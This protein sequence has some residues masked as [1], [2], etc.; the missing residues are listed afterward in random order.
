MK[1]AC[2]RLYHHVV[3]LFSVSVPIIFGFCDQVLAEWTA[4]DPD[5]AKRAPRMTV[6]KSD[7]LSTVVRFNVFGFEQETVEI[8]GSAYTHITLPGYYESDRR[9]YP[10]VPRLHRDFVIPPS[11]R[12]SLKVLKTRKVTRDLGALKPSRGLLMRSENPAD[13]PYEFA[14]LYRQGGVYPRHP[15]DIGRPFTMRSVRGVNLSFAPFSYNGATG[16]T[17]ITTEMVVEIRTA[18]RSPEPARLQPLAYNDQAFL[19]I[20]TGHFANFKPFTDSL[21]LRYDFVP[22]SGRLLVITH[23]EFTDTVAALVDWKRQSGLDVDLITTEAETSYRDIK[24]LVKSAYETDHVGYVLLAGDAEFIPYHVGTSGNVNGNEADPM[25]ALVAGNDSYPDLFVSR[26]SAQND[27]Q[28][29]NLVNRIISYERNPDPEADWYAKAVGIASSEGNPSDKQRADILREMM[30]GW[31]YTDVDQIYDPGAQASRLT[32]ALNEG[33]GY[34]NYIGHG[35]KT[36]WGT[37]GFSNSHI[38]SLANGNM[39]P[40]I[41][42]VACVNGDF[43]SGGDSFAERWLKAGSPAEPKGAI[44]VLASSTNQSWV[45]PTVG[46][47][48]VINLLTSHRATTI[49]GLFANGMAAMLESGMSGAVQTFQSWHTF[50]DASLMVR[51]RRPSAIIASFPDA[52]LLG[53]SQLTITT[54]TPGIRAGLMQDG[55]L[56]G[57]GITDST[58][59]LQIEFSEPPVVGEIRVTLTGFNKTPSVRN[60][61]VIPP[62]GPYLI[63]SGFSA[64][65]RTDT[66]V[67][68][69][70]TVHVGFDLENI[71]S[72]GSSGGSLSILSLDGPAVAVQPSASLPPL[73]VNQT[74]RIEETVAFKVTGRAEDG[75]VVKVTM[76]WTVPEEASETTTTTFRITRGNIIV[77]A[78]DFGSP[79]I[80]G[81]DPGDSGELFLTLAN[82]GSET[83]TAVE[84][85]A[86]PGNCLTDIGGD[87]SISSL[88]PS[89]S[90]RLD[91]PLAATVSAECAAGDDVIFELGGHLREYRRD[92]GRS[93]RHRRLHRR[94][95]HNPRVRGSGGLTQH[96][97]QQHR[98]PHTGCYRDSRHQ[99]HQRPH[100]NHPQPSQ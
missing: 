21:G 89:A 30:L 82:T 45:E 8:D 68:G 79:A 63:L 99:G 73:A 5:Q 49:G 4:L 34:I 71:G 86:L 52:L 83:L 98:R 23:P 91:S 38:D 40:V 69:N 78:I 46:Q 15:V 80:T 70:E 48:E 58:G 16:L 20:Y 50:G 17:T 14:D 3:L 76:Q 44:A 65:N 33:R 10:A 28:M 84:L 53:Q 97:Q 56:I 36:A 1:T 60:V 94:P 77:S 29:T 75:A 54:E 66:V 9:G 22:E 95:Y 39:L 18:T 92:K 90:I 74:T 42:S 25:Y 72:E 62:Q 81:I 6:V 55:R 35:S 2:T 12:A 87:L 26:L 61:R 24:E 93:D 43:S 11:A 32:A 100:Q 47:K 85:S 19:D 59:R 67:Y 37:T 27:E 31:H 57:N 51:T 7:Q 88:A 13:V 41:V 96:T 64:N